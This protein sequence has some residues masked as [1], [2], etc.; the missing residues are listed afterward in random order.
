MTALIAAAL[1][2]C[3]D[4]GG[5]HEDPVNP[6]DPNN[7]ERPNWIIEEAE[8]PFEIEDN[9]V[10]E[11]SGN[12]VL[13]GDADGGT[14]EKVSCTFGGESGVQTTEVDGGVDGSKCF[15]IAQLRNAEGEDD[16]WQEFCCDITKFYGQGKSFLLS[17]KLKADPNAAADKCKSEGEA[18]SVGYAVY[19]GAVKNWAVAKSLKTGKEYEYYDFDDSF[20]P[21]PWGHGFTKDESIAQELG[22]YLSDGPVLATGEWTQY[23]YV[24]PATTIEEAVNNTGLCNMTVSI[25]MGDDAISGY[26]YLLDDIVIKDLNVEVD[27]LGQT[28]FDPTKEPEEGAE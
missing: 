24:I 14:A 10:G 25:Y 18:L 23:N 26:S 4:N 21:G 17:F 13:N 11:V 12:L 27:R 1:I 8:W 15:R 28:W 2:S 9:T 16:K 22:V 20:E 19:S 5:G 7:G 3:S 6:P